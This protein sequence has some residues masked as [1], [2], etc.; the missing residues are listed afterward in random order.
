M[1]CILRCFSARHFCT[2]WLSDYYSYFCRLKPVCTFFFIAPL[3]V[4][5]QRENPR[6]SAVM[7]ILIPARLAPTIMQRSKSLR[8]HSFFPSLSR[9][10]WTLPESVGLYV[11]FSL[12]ITHRMTY[13]IVNVWL[14]YTLGPIENVPEEAVAACWSSL[15]QWQSRM[16]PLCAL[17]SIFKPQLLCFSS[18]GKRNCSWPS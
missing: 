2:E 7:K 18:V 11:I 17:I 4:N 10:M 3:W 16:A 12:H 15:Y 9:L 1:L 6:R 8:S 5:C 14:K 13:D